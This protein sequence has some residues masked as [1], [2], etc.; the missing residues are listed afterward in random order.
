MVH[1]SDGSDENSQPGSSCPCPVRHS[2]SCATHLGQQ[3]GIAVSL[4][5]HVM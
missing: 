1:G 3:P 4:T 2:S 5:P